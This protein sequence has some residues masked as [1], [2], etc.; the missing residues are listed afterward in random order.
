MK[1]VKCLGIGQDIRADS[2]EKSSGETWCTQ[3]LQ[4]NS[5]PWCLQHTLFP[6]LYHEI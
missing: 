1:M 5:H 2:T 6:S 4:C 3:T